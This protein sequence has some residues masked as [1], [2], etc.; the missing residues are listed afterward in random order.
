MAVVAAL[1]EEKD[2]RAVPL[3]G[4]ILAESDPVGGDHA[5]VLETLDAIAQIRGEQAIPQVSAVMRR[6]GWFAR[7]KLRAIKQSS[8]SV[9][10]R[11]G[12]PAAQQAL[13]AAA[14][15]GDRLLKKLARAALSGAAAHG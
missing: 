10:Q 1:V 7:K 3:L 12:T 8:I 14:D 13:A 6:R 11:I 9:L 2:Q 4:R 15:D 5:I